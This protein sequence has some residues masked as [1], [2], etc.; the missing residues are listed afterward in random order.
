M[1]DLEKTK[2]LFEQTCLV[3]SSSLSVEQKIRLPTDLQISRLFDVVYP[4][5]Q[6]KLEEKLTENN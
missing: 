5:L 3:I 6:K 4:V 1:N 2:F